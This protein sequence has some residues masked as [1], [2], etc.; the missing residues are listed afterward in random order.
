[1]MRQFSS[2]LP[3]V[4]VLVLPIA[5]GR[6]QGDQKQAVRAPFELGSEEVRAA[7]NLAESDLDIPERPLSA[8][9]RVVF[10]KIDLLPD[11]QAETTQR[12]VNVIHYRYRGDETII[13]TIDL[14][15]R[16]VLNRQMLPH[17]PTGLAPEELTRAQ[18]LAQGDARLRGLFAA[19]RLQMEGRPLQSVSRQDD[20]FGHRVVHLLLRDG[21][22]YLT[23][24]RV[25]VDL[26]TEAVLVDDPADVSK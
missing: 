12:Q 17:F 13:T 22:A 7:R 8:L 1:M 23:T 18:Q 14:N 20:L 10:I 16:E 3:L 6:V 25:L 11:A 26:T 19:R 4:L 9:D 5:C 24:P 21:N 15:R 2:R